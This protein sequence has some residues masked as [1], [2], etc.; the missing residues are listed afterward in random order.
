MGR[1]VV[2]AVLVHGVGEDVAIVTLGNNFIADLVVA[3][4]VVEV[5]N[6]AQSGIAIGVANVA[7]GLA[8]DG[9]DGGE[10]DL[11]TGGQNEVSGSKAA[12]AALVG[13]PLDLLNDEVV[14][15]AG[16]ETD[17]VLVLVESDHEVGAL[18]LV[19]LELVS[20]LIGG[21]ADHGGT[22]SHANGA[23]P[24][25]NVAAGN[26]VRSL[27]ALNGSLGGDGGAGVADGDEDILTNGEAGSLNALEG[28]GGLV[29]QVDSLIGLEVDGS[30][31]HVAVRIGV[32][33]RDLGDLSQIGVDLNE[34]DLAVRHDVGLGD[35]ALTADQ[36]SGGE[37]VDGG[38]LVGGD[39]S[40][41]QGHG[42]GIDEGLL[43]SGGGAD[44]EILGDVALGNLGVV[45]SVSLLG[46][47]G[48]LVAGGVGP[49]VRGAAPNVLGVF[50]QRQ[51]EVLNAEA[52]LNTN[53][54]VGDITESG[55]V[56][57]AGLLDGLEQQ[58]SNELTGSGS[59]QVLAAGVLQNAELLSGLSNVK[60]PVLAGELAVLVITHGTQDHGKSLITGDVVERAERG[61]VV[62][63]DETG[64]GAVA[65][66]ALRPV[67]AGQIVELAV[68]SVQTNVLVGHVGS[69]DAVND[70]SHFCAGDSA[71]RLE[72][73]IGVAL[74][75]AHT[76]ENVSGFRIGLI[77]LVGI[78][79]SCVG[80]DGQGQ[81]HD[82]SQHQCE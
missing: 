12:D 55:R 48:L 73:A 2:A 58:L 78:S 8:V 64:V 18:V 56:G 9:G 50:L 70:R 10:G 77:D 29:V 37:R 61:V 15:S 30:V 23:G 27:N 35:A 80:T 51:R 57:H 65:D 52:L 39:S 16:N 67:G 26:D 45:D 14:D 1:D 19:Q 11:L 76:S 47:D 31:D 71:F 75:D 3:V 72:G 40:V 62:A 44:A 79:K 4:V 24:T 13:L 5:G 17:D 82:Q 69:V 6:G 54:G 53:D 60:L 38:V 36:R 25:G 20:F 74:K 21:G 22:G 81:S 49:G 41:G 33:S 63:A 32:G 59:S 66:V 28:P 7:R 46:D 34:T 68:A 43:Q 42:L